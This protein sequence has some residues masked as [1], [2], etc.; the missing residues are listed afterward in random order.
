MIVPLQARSQTLGT[1]TL[2]SAES[3]RLYGEEDLAFAPELARRAA[4][5]IDNA[6]LHSELASRSQELGFLADASEQLDATLDL[7]ETLQKLADLG[8]AV[9]WRRLHGGPA[10]RSER[11]DPAR[12]RRPPPR[13]RASPCSTRLRDRRI[14]LDSPHP[15]ALAMRTGELQHVAE[16]TTTC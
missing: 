8:G 12:R 11:H 1:I 6:R 5:S 3:E 10:R 13:I 7:E 9:P 2:V 15:I 4:L 16:I 14:D